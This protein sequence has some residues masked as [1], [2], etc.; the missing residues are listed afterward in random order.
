MTTTAKVSGTTWQSRKGQD[1]GL[2]VFSHGVSYV[3]IAYGATEAS[4]NTHK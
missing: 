4:G 3:R 1:A 2:A